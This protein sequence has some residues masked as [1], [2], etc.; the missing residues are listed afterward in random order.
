MF[1]AEFRRLIAESRKVKTLVFN[2]L[3]KSA[4]NL[5]EKK[6]TYWTPP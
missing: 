1:L 6:E 5:R 3:R 2:I 4:I